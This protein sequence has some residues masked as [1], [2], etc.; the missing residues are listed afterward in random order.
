MNFCEI[1]GMA[2]RNLIWDWCIHRVSFK[3]VCG[4]L[5]LVSQLIKVSKFSSFQQLGNN[6]NKIGN[7]FQNDVLCVP[8]SLSNLTHA[9]IFRV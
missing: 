5:G 2:Y 7:V 3:K 8:Y 9:T 1:I 4:F 6:S